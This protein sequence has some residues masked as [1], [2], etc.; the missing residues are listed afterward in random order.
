MHR[1]GQGAP[2]SSPAFTGSRFG[3]K[4]RNGGLRRSKGVAAARARPTARQVAAARIANGNELKFHDVDVDQAVDNLSAGKILNTDTINI[5]PQNVTEKGRIGRKC[6]IKSVGWRGELTFTNAAGSGGAVAEIIRLMLV[7]DTQANAAAPTV[8]GVLES[9]NYQSFNNL[10]NKGRFHTYS[11]KTYVLNPQSGAGN[12][13]ANDFGAVTQAFEIFKR[14]DVPLEF[15]G[16][17]GTIDELT[18][19]NFFVLIISKGTASLTAMDSKVRLR[20][21]DG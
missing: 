11:D 15:T 14:M 12:G 1:Q 18:S 21:L 20:F 9:A 16:A 13:T 8:T 2:R 3:Q 4:F 5:I 7:L 6:V 17:A 19:N 10:A